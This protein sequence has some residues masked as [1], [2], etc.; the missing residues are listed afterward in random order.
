M[1]ITE[2]DIAELAIGSRAAWH[3]RNPGKCNPEHELHCCH[4]VYSRQVPAKRGFL[5]SFWKCSGCG[6]GSKT[7]VLIPAPRR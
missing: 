4:I 1:L 5:M 6:K 3:A 7:A 2:K